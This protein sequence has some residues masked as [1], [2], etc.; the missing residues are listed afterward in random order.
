[1]KINWFT[2]IAQAINFLVLMW[3]LKKYLYKPILKAID[4]RETKILGQLKDAESKKAESL[5]EREEYAQKI[6]TFDTQKEGMLQKAVTAANEEGLRLM[7][8]SRKEANALKERLEKS[9]FEEQE[10]RNHDMVRHIEKEVLEIA[11]KTL[12]ELSSVGMEEQA[13]N[14]FLQKIKS[15]TEQEKKQFLSALGAGS[16][17]I[18][19]RSAFELTGKLQTDIQKRLSEFAGKGCH[20][21]FE[22][23]PELIGGIEV[24]VNG[25]RLSWNIAAYVASLEKDITAGMQGALTVSSKIKEDD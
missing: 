19:V 21:T 10:K 2:L 3:L 17:S 14:T 4:E 24:T 13:V 23:S 18:L 8:V 9:L 16:N 6:R 11:R 22:I 7:E 20:F 5:K 1:M 12:S 25:Y 15:L